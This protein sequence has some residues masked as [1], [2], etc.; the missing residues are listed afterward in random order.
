MTT[1][2]GRARWF[3]RGIGCGM[4][5]IPLLIAALITYMR[6]EAGLLTTSTVEVRSGEW[7]LPPLK[8]AVVAD[9][10]VKPEQDALE[11][12][13]KSVAMTN[14]VAADLILLPGDFA[15]GHRPV[16][17]APPELVAKELAQLKAP[18]GV[19]AIL[20]NHDRWHGAASWINALTEAGIPLLENRSVTLGFH[21]QRFHLVGASDAW[22][23]SE[24]E[25]N[26]LLPDDSLPR[27]IMTHT[28]D[29]YST[30]PEGGNALAVA[31]HTHG[32]QIVIPFYG[33]PFV[34]S[35]FDQRYASG[36]VREGRNTIYITRGVGTSVLPLRFRC[37]P[38]IS[39]LM[40]QGE[41]P[42]VPEPALP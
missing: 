17:G 21:G 33:A 31:G 42:T 37:K 41:K 14:A 12:L 11:R 7:T 25:W 15:A 1:K 3:L 5:L 8:I 19:Y 6:Y 20:G 10:H 24:E 34:P 4:F 13:R 9:F 22:A 32:G 40:L 26:S 35:R 28:P 2:P 27:I 29:I 23:R 39:I 16:Q 30:L 18:L 38:E 36:V